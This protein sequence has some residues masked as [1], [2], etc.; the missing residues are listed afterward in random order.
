M[1][2]KGAIRQPWTFLA[3]TAPLCLYYVLLAVMMAGMC[4]W[5]SFALAIAT[6]VFLGILIPIGV[7]AQLRCDRA[8]AEVTA[9]LVCFTN[10]NEFESEAVEHRHQRQRSKTPRS[11]RNPSVASRI[12]EEKLGYDAAADNAFNNNT[13]NNGS[14]D[15]ETSTHLGEQRLSPTAST[16]LTSSSA[17]DVKPMSFPVL[18]QSWLQNGTTYSSGEEKNPS[19]RQTHLRSIQHNHNMSIDSTRVE[20]LT[21]LSLA[22]QCSS[23]QPQRFL[24]YEEDDGGAVE[25]KPNPALAEMRSLDREEVENRRPMAFSIYSQTTLNESPLGV[26]S[27][28]PLPVIVQWVSIICLILLEILLLAGSFWIAFSSEEGIA[29]IPAFYAPFILMHFMHLLRFV[30]GDEKDTVKSNCIS[31]LAHPATSLFVAI[32]GMILYIF[33]VAQ[34]LRMSWTEPYVWG[35]D[36]TVSMALR[37][38]YYLSPLPIVVAPWF[39]RG[40]AVAARVGGMR[41]STAGKYKTP[42]RA[43]SLQRGSRSR[44]HSNPFHQGRVSA[45]RVFHSDNELDDGELSSIQLSQCPSA[46]ATRNCNRS[47]RSIVFTS[48]GTAAGS[49]VSSVHHAVPVGFQPQVKSVTLLYVAYR[50]PRRVSTSVDGERREFINNKNPKELQEMESANFQALLNAAKEMEAHHGPFILTAHRDAL[51]FVCGVQPFSA[52]PILWAV[53]TANDFFKVFVPPTKSEN[54]YS[55]VAA[56]LYAPHALISI[57]G[58]SEMCTVHFLGNEHYVGEQLLSRGFLLRSLEKQ[59]RSGKPFSTSGL[60]LDYRAAHLAASRI[61]CRP[62]GIV[63]NVSSTWTTGSITGANSPSKTMLENY[64]VI[65]DFV[66]RINEKHE[67]WHLAA[68]TREQRSAGFLPAVEAAQAFF[69]GNLNA[70]KRALG[71]PTNSEHDALLQLMSSD[72]DHIMAVSKG[73]RKTTE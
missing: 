13:S 25:D 16:S 41:A 15:N 68:E 38:V 49:H 42:R 36:G 12:R 69:Q 57:V 70:A 17:T 54:N 64:T 47:G 24:D 10:P 14:N 56:V 60:L 63:P 51:C 7:I 18:R 28:K 31:F 67:E 29:A 9:P 23:N 4:R 11:L 50:D 62:V 34:S 32:I 43:P 55:L 45:L 1:K 52:D 58:T 22:T 65:Y 71:N 48:S 6:I 3:V 61:L 46:S 37:A 21:K 27:I 66:L 73:S 40:F 30:S 33:A 72:V 20:S 59:R 44:S 19:E 35:C 2:T 26:S 39:G 53:D 5:Y 8:N